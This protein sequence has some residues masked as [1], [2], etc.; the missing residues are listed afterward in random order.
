[1]NPQEHEVSHLE[2]YKLL[3]EVKT[4]LDLTLKRNEEDR[5]QN[6]KD[7]TEIYHRIGKLENRMAQVVVVALAISV[8]IPVSVELLANSFVPSA[9]T[10][11]RPK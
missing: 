6:A 1:M 11:N 8:L 4:T 7:K 9:Q 5:V 3:I 10:I 2:I